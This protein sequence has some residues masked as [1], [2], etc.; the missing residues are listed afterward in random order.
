MNAVLGHNAALKRYTGHRPIRANK[1]N[2][3]VYHALGAGPIAGSV[4]LQSSALPLY[5]DYTPEQR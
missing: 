1:M 3:G 2:F 5:Y 4:D